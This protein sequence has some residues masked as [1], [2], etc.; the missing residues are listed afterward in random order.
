MTYH[1]D[2]SWCADE[3]GCHLC[4]VYSA[5]VIVTYNCVERDPVNTAV[6]VDLI[7][8]EVDAMLILNASWELLLASG[9]NHILLGLA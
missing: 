2:D 4:G 9:A 1:R 7:D 5:T 6:A 8:G 3:I